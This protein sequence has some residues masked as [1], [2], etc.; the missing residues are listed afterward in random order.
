MVNCD[1][2]GGY[3]IPKTIPTENSKGLRK[4]LVN[5]KVLKP[6]YIQV[7]TYEYLNSLLSE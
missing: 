4:L 6:I 5:L 7:N 1:S 3:L 2:D